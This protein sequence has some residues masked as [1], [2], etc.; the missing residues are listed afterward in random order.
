[1]HLQ[2]LLDKREK[3]LFK[4]TY[5]ALLKLPE[6]QMRKLSIK[7]ED[8]P[9]G[10]IIFQLSQE[11]TDDNIKK[12]LLIIE[13]KS[14]SDLL[15]S[16]KDGR[17]EEQSYRLINSSGLPPHSIFYL[18]EGMFSQVSEKDKK[19]I[20]ST[21][22]SVN[23]FKGFSVLRTSSIYETGELLI[24]F[25]DK[26]VRDM[27]KGRVPYIMQNN[28]NIE[29]SN[30][31]SST[32]IVKNIIDNFE[33][34]AVTQSQTSYCNF[35]KK[36]KRDNITPENIGEIMLC[37]IPG[38]SSVTAIAIM[39]KFSTIL[40]LIAELQD[41]PNCLNDIMT[42]TNGKSRKISKSCIES[43]KQFLL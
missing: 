15:A 14:F 17:Y 12:Q 16:I 1:M 23:I 32:S 19:I 10:D 21:M 31:N 11:S 20:Y 30:E 13:R 9:I 5:E 42:D 40:N 29:D 4:Y 26:I 2:I 41:N 39:K 24:G 43:I 3:E 7:Y 6:V 18:L 28:Q 8:L 34:D 37:Q 35:V 27:E 38:I 36:V 22:A 33:S 25:A